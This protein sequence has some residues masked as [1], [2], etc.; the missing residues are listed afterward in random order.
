M[1][2]HPQDP[3]K[4][5][6]FE[7]PEQ[8]IV[9]LEEPD[10]ISDET[11]IEE[12]TVKAEVLPFFPSISALLQEPS[13]QLPIIKEL[14]GLLETKQPDLRIPNID[15]M[16]F[17]QAI[18]AMAEEFA[19]FPLVPGADLTR[20][21][22]DAGLVRAGDPDDFYNFQATE[23]RPLKGPIGTGIIGGTVRG[24][25]N[26]TKSLL[27]NAPVTIASFVTA[28]FMIAYGGI[29]EFVQSASSLSG[30]GQLFSD[31]FREQFGEITGDMILAP[32]KLSPHEAT[33]ARRAFLG[34]LASAAVGGAL[35]K[36]IG[37]PIFRTSRQIGAT[38][39]EALTQAR[40]IRAQV[41]AV[42]ALGVF[43]AVGGEPTER[44]KNFVNY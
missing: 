29:R 15:R 32:A 36:T 6:F 23:I 3:K 20:T 41:T 42:S 25:L 1:P 11:I 12:E 4:P 21:P 17:D 28:P 18:G 31:E 19:P 26:I 9:F 22:V 14:I 30:D 40:F 2:Q 27:H 10:P 43:G 33:E 35:F 16:T 44:D 39:A 7:D 5:V 34:L 13:P 24:A 38:K 8:G 37:R